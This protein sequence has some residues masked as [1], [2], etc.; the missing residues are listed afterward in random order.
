MLLLELSPA[1]LIYKYKVGC[2]CWV[3][4]LRVPLE[5]S[6]RLEQHLFLSKVSQLH[7]Q[8]DGLTLSREKWGQSSEWGSFCP[9]IYLHFIYFWLCWVFIAAWDFPLVSASGGYSLVAVCGLL[10]VLASL[11]AEAQTLGP[12]GFSSRSTWAQ[13]LRSQDLERGLSSC[14]AGAQ[15][16]HSMWDPPLWGIEPMSPALAGGI[17]TNEPPGKSFIF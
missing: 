9:V 5:I 1:L 8:K 14:S 13:W 10:I 4:I 11:V 12:S 16:L 2:I 17:F 3:L 7:S 15:L 6:C